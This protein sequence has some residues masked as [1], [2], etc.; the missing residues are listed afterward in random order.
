MN[1]DQGQVQG[2]GAAYEDGP[3]RIKRLWLQRRF[4]NPW[5]YIV[6]GVLLVIL[7]VLDLYSRSAAWIFNRA[8]ENQELL[9]GSITAERI[10]AS[11]IG[12]VH[13]EG[14][15]WKDPE[16]RRI[17]YIPYGEFT[18][19]ILDALLQHFSSTSIE[20]LAINN[21]KLSVRLN[22][23]MSVDFIR[24]AAP[25]EKQKPKPRLKSRNE[26]KTEAQLLAE[27]EE[28]RQKQRQEMER[29]WKNF[30]HSGEWLDLH[31]F[32]DNCLME[33]FYRE[34]HYQLEA[35]RLNIDLDSRDKMKIKL[36]TGPFGGDMI[37]SG[38]FLNG[39]ID[40]RKTI[41]QCDLMLLIDAVDP[42]SL[43]FGMDVHDPLSMAV[44]FEGD[45]P[46]PVGRGTLHFDRLRIPAL[47]FRN[48]DGEIDYENALIKFT[49]VYADVYGGKLSA[50]GWYNIDT[51]YYHIS[52][53]GENLR[54]RKALPDAGL[55]CLVELDIDV[56]SKGSA[57]STSYGGTFTSG[58]GR[59]RWMPFKA[60][61]GR[62]HNA[63][64]KL[65]FY[66]VLIDFGGVTATTDAFHID[67]GKLS[68]SPIKVT[69]EDGKPLATYDPETKTLIDE[70]PGAR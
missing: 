46:S 39:K 57:Q 19:D 3:A 66:D 59:Y 32:L 23:D 5:Y 53:H 40:F 45:L 50:E 67:N 21:A 27:G 37:G 56:D 24:Q 65:D 70:R 12:H 60:L 51:R 48:V 22:E 31:I 58:A 14:L 63:S 15:D 11:P 41:P 64:K 42:S 68:L 6:P 2:P 9:R 36:A 13:F 52:G 26:E 7:L 28:K 55:H 29:E 43:G 62:F 49:E 17:L 30:N 54:A 25:G 8:M 69:G 47:D 35:I 10:L 1:R 16:G 33:V 20:R 38:I 4:S 34:R 61:A 44:R 18:V